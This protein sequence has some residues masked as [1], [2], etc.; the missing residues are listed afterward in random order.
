MGRDGTSRRRGDQE[1][2][3]R[4]AEIDPITPLRA[5]QDR[6][7]DRHQ[8]DGPA[9]PDRNHVVE[10]NE[11]QKPRRVRLAASEPRHA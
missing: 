4:D 6:S 3:V 7:L 5:G 2:K 1:V 9:A 10:L 11:A 8:A